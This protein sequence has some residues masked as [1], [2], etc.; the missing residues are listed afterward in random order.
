MTV[1]R[2]A[3][4]LPALFLACSSSSDEDP[5]PV[6]NPT[7]EKPRHKPQVFPPLLDAPTT[8]EKTLVV[9]TTKQK[10]TDGPNPSAT[11]EALD[12][13][14]NRGFGDLVDG[15]G[16]E[17][18]TRVIDDSTPPAP[19]PNAKRILRFVHLADTQLADDESPT[20]LGQFDSAGSTSSALRPQDAYLCH[21]A[22][23]SVRTINA[24]H[25]KDPIA[26]TLLGGD[27]ADSAQSDEVGWILGI[28]SGADDI[29]C[30]SGNNDEIIDGP[31]NDGKDPFKAEGLKM[32]WK[33]VTGNHDVLVQGNLVVDDAQKAKAL[34]ADAFG[35][36]R[37]YTDGKRGAVERGEG[38]SIADPRRA[39]LTRPELMA[40]VAANGDG[41]GIGEAEK[42]S[43]MATYTFDAEGTSFRFLVVD[44]AHEK[45]GSEG[46][47]RQAEVDRV[48]KPALDK[49][50]A[51]GKWVI[52]SSHHA[53]SSIGDGSGFGG[54][55]GGIPDALTPEKWTELLV[56]YD[57]VL[58]FMVGHS[59]RHRV[60]KIEPAAGAS[61]HP[62]WEVMTAAI[63]DYPH[64][65]R[66][67]DLFDQDNGWIMMRATCVDFSV[68]GDPIAAEGR[69]RGVVDLTSGWLPREAGVEANDRNVELWIKKP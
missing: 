30:D 17:Y 29:E 19:G 2:F 24:L 36:T 59:H 9:K 27:N 10:D 4:A 56:G 28:L 53:I 40:K 31:D 44:T 25:A 20:R 15:P 62:F 41:H 49:A 22:N 52:L 65:F 67:I 14:L 47:V 58:F 66:T 54:V 46:V 48:I 5:P 12:D 37:V 50:K 6:P 43:G 13:Y 18:A 34:T 64:Q 45:G 32:P 1:R 16:E 21:M 7:V 26:F 3:W 38:I 35:G 42:A 51:D 11:P 57:N 61:G 23:A 63:A 60:R 33:W 8:R 68:E 55:S 39:L 69:R